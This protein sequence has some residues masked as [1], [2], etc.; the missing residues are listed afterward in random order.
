MANKDIKSKKFTGVYYRI[1]QDG[2]KTFFIVY[3]DPI[4]KKTTRLKI[5]T[6]KE[7][8]NEQYSYNMKNEIITKTRLGEDPNIPI[9]K[10]KQNKTNINDLAKNYFDNLFTTKGKNKSTKQNESRYN[11][12]IA[13]IIGHLQLTQLTKQHAKKIQKNLLD[14]GLSS[15]T[16]NHVLTLIKTIIN[17]NLK[18]D[19]VTGSNPLYG[20]E[21]LKADNERKRY[22]RHDEVEV[23]LKHTNKDK[24]LHLF[25]LLALSTG[26]RLHGVLSI[27]KKDIDLT[28]NTIKIHDLKSGGTYQGFIHPE[29]KPLLE[30]AIHGLKPNG[31]VI[32][33]KKGEQVEDKRIQRPLKVIFDN[34]FNTYLDSNDR[35]NRVVVHT[36]RHTF[37]SLLAIEG[38][39]IF[40]IQKLMNHKDIKM[41]LRYAKLAPDSGQEAVNKLFNFK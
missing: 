19:L 10:A 12:Q 33:Y 30:D 2:T 13:P 9:L 25:T 32:S 34:L 27:Q 24:V 20:I 17:Y 11:R 23:L 40:T 38:M 1:A 18:N 31:Y 4:T 35:L 14:E 41:T 5:G 8:F 39:P 29:V 36:L 26:A 22:L 7:G 15:T 3:K 6:D 37:A 28:N 21:L 16:I